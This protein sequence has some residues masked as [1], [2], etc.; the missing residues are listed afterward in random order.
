MPRF[1]FIIE[2]PPVS[3][4]AKEG[5]PHARKRYRD[6]MSKVNTAASAVWPEGQ[7][8]TSSETVEV[9]ITNYFTLAPPEI[10]NIIKPILDALNNLVY[11]DDKQVFR[12]VSE[13]VDL[14]AASISNPDPLL[15]Q[16]LATYDEIVHVIVIW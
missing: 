10:D 11:E 4:N 2:G 16:A 3:L 1:A 13:R 7:T 6:W 5:K 8:A 14:Q 9:R 15:A 12:V